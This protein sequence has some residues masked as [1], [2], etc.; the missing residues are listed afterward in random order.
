MFYPLGRWLAY[1]FPTLGHTAN[2]TFLLLSLYSFPSPPSALRGFPLHCWP[3]SC[4]SSSR[5]MV[6]AQGAGPA[7]SPVAECPVWFLVLPILLSAHLSSKQPQDTER[8]VVRPGEAGT[9]QWEKRS[10]GG[11]RLAPS[12]FRACGALG[13]GFLQPSHQVDARVV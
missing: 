7:P 8:Q 13:R 10:E 3:P 9:E 4:S 1:H 12:I 6:P 5:A 11:Q 2:F